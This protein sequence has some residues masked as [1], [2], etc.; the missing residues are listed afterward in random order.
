MK[1][2]LWVFG[3]SYTQD[4]SMEQLRELDHSTKDFFAVHDKISWFLAGW[5]FKLAD[6]LKMEIK[7]FGI[8]GS[9]LEYSAQKYSENFSNFVNG[10]VVIFAITQLSRKYL[11][12]SKPSWSTP[13]RI[14]D[15]MR[16]GGYTENDIYFYRRALVENGLRPNET[17]MRLLLHSSAILT[18]RDITVL[19]IPCFPD[20]ETRLHDH[21]E[22]FPGS[23]NETTGNLYANIS[24]LEI[25]ERFRQEANHSGTD[26][27]LNHMH[28]L[29]HD[30]LINKLTDCII[31]KIPL[32]LVNGFEQEIF[33]EIPKKET[34]GFF[35]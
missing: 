26:F 30:I 35:Q 20:A 4:L 15:E 6:N 10:D 29:N 21:R 24:R 18:N 9:S 11:I 14:D 19:F 3:D 22:L 17:I 23:I 1:S 2:T 25:T 27:R 32:D 33:D 13:W 12:D 5:P 16:K 31:N 34:T 7:N 28:K 8:T